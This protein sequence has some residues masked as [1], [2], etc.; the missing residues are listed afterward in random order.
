MAVTAPSWAPI[1]SFTL[2]IV[3]LSLRPGRRDVTVATPHRASS[4]AALLLACVPLL[5]LPAFYDSLLYLVLHWVVLATSWNILSGYIGL[6]LVR[7]RRVLRR[8]PVH[9]GTLLARYDWPF[10]WTLPVAAA[11]AAALGVALGAVVFRVAARARRAVRAAHAGGHLR[12]R[13]H[14]RQHA[15]RR[16]PGR[17]AERGAGAAHRRRR[18]RRPSTCWRSPRRWPRCSIAWA[19]YVSR[20]G[21]G[22]FAIHD[23]EDAAE[24]MGVPT[25]RY[26]LAAL[27]ISC[28]LAGA[29]RRH[30]RAVPLV[31]HRRRGVHDHGAA[32]GGADERARRHA[33]LGRAGGRRGRDHRRC[34]TAFT[35]ADHAVAGKAAIGA[36]LIAAILFMPDGILPRLQRAFRRARAG[37]RR[38]S[39]AHAIGSRPRR[40]SRRAADRRGDARRRGV[41]LRCTGL[42]K[43]FKGVQRARRRRRR[44]AA[45]RDPR[46]A[47]AE[48]LGQVDLHQ[49]RQRPLR[50]E[51]RARSSSRAASIARPRRRTASPRAGIAR[52]YQIPRPF[53][54][55]SVLDNVALAAMFGGGVPAIAARRAARR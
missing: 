26:K 38:R 7:P 43:S 27:A 44:G 22:L 1:V 13:H 54:H 47:R 6:L 11:V 28:A 3:V 42:H 29:G 51:R 18:R 33:P 39:S 4:A 16:R 32:D 2:L 9:D 52:T 40:R 14:R 8:R 23:D 49:R 41:L 37:A 30:P 20:F 17:L 53:A 48:R 55:L 5:G 46:P 25:Y 50:A 10:L 19:I 45:R 21:A 24:V 35:A 31:R 34:C 15:D 36:I 12:P